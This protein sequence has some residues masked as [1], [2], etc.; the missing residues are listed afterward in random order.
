MATNYSYAYNNTVPF[1][2]VSPTIALAAS[3]ELTYTV[4]GNTSSRYRVNFSWAYNANVWVCVNGTAAVP[5]PGTIDTA[6]RCEYRPG[7]DGSGRYVKGGDVIH[8]IS[9]AIT[10]GGFSL[11]LLP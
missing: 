1:S 8:F 7:S 5:T 6:S 11:F 10:A 4:P 3:T 2:D 9:D